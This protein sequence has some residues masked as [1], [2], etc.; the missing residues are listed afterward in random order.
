MQASAQ[1]LPAKPWGFERR[2]YDADHV[3]P[4]RTQFAFADEIPRYWLN[5]NPA[6]THLMNA[7]HLFLPPFER[8]L[9]QAVRRGALPVLRDPALIRQA[10]GYM[11]Q[12]TIHGCCHDLFVDHLRA[13]GYSVDRY[14]ALLDWL[15]CDLLQKRLGAKLGVSLVAAFEHHANLFVP[16]A[17]ST[18]F[19]DGCEPAVREL[20]EWHLAEE[21]EHNAV[22]FD[23]LQAVAPGQALRMAG[24]LLALVVLYSSLVVGALFLLWQDRRLLQRSVWAELGRFFVGKYRVVQNAAALFVEYARADYRPDPS[25]HSRLAQ[26]VLSPGCRSHESSR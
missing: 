1:A 9:T 2:A 18:D 11:G 26:A 10:K 25:R 19:L 12:E 3:R 22:A 15:F 21:V 4:R 14:G 13:Q 6:R 8:M 16:L 20:L 23:I 24:N 7:M 5:G 17:F